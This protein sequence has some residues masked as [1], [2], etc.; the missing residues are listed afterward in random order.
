MDRIPVSSS[1]IESIGYDEDSGT[2]EIE[3]KNGT[4]YQYF[5]VPAHVHTSL[6][7]ASSIGGFLASTIKGAYRYSKV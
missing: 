5:D 3:F 6:I 7:S 2:L 4:L 1:N